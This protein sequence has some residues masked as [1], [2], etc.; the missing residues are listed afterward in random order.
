[1]NINVKTIIIKLE[2]VQAYSHRR[3]IFLLGLNLIQNVPKINGSDIIKNFLIH[4]KSSKLGT[5]RFGP[6]CLVVFFSF[7]FIT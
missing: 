6:I 2:Q 3:V 1:M 5:Y 7:N 4:L